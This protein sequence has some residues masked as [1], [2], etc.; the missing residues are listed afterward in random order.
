MLINPDGA[1]G[2]SGNGEI[3]FQNSFLANGGIR[4]YADLGE[5]G[6]M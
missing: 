6:F 1:N 4:A 5:W 2:N 3:Y